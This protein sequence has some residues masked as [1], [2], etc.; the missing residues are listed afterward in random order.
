LTGETRTRFGVSSVL[1][2]VRQGYATAAIF[3][4]I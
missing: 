3:V 4:D 2:F 1:N